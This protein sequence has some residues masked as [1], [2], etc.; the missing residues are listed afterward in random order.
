[1]AKQL[2]VP[3]YQNLEQMIENVQLDVVA[4][5]AAC[6]LSRLFWQQKMELA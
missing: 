4:Y 3:G 2:K 5:R 6:M 1:M